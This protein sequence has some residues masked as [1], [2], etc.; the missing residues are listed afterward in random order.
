MEHQESPLTHGHRH[1]EAHGPPPAGAPGAL[2][3]AE[4]DTSPALWVYERHKNIVSL[5]FKVE[6]TLFSAR[7]PYQQIDIVETAGHGRMLLNDGVVMISERDEFVYHEMIAHVP[8]LTHPNPRRVLIV[9]GGDGGTAR[10][11]LK[12]QAVERVVMV[13]IDEMVVRA[14]REHMPSVSGALSDPRLTLLLEDGVKY[15]A[16]SN[17]S[18][19]LAIIDSTDPVGPAAPLFDSAFY[20]NTAAL[21]D[22][23][24][25]M[26]TQSE[27]P[28]YD[29]E[30][31]RSMFT[32]QRPHFPRLH[33]YL[34]ST[35]TY[36][37]GL[38]SFGYASKGPCPVRDL[39][40][41]RFKTFAAAAGTGT[42]AAGDTRPLVRYYTP[43]VHRAA[44]A[45]PRFVDDAVS[46][47]LDPALYSDGEPPGLHRGG[48]T[49]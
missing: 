41:T 6:A 10:E 28:F 43:A 7:S 21:L 31:Q 14:C 33:M 36:P 30:I 40:D 44:F 48:F 2:D 4:S 42:D 24:G 29:P 22:E 38:W 18:F 15:V 9:G 37:G 35:L 5:G 19:D 45:L 39:D 32:N 12:H 46:D 3:T 20:R 34:F 26:I 27:S 8:L 13:E 16:E 1:G 23:N 47:L 49:G 11:V 17:D 25:V